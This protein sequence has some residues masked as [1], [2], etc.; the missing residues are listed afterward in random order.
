M[1]SAEPAVKNTCQMLM[2][3]LFKIWNVTNADTSI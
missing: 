3:L 1:F 2:K